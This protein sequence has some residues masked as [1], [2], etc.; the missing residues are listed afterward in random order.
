M[1]VFITEVIPR[2]HWRLHL[3]LCSVSMQT[4]MHIAIDIFYLVN[5]STHS[6]E[7]RVLIVYTIEYSLLFLLSV[8]EMGSHKLDVKSVVINHSKSAM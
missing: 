7:I 6:A 2:S 8:L 3:H 5:V 4:Y 1:D